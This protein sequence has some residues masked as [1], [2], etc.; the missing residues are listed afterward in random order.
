VSAV[1]TISIY[2]HGRNGAIAAQFLDWF[3]GNAYAIANG[4]NHLSTRKN[5]QPN[6][7]ILSLSIQ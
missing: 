2:R 7:H 5:I 3:S 1:N 4:R 6:W